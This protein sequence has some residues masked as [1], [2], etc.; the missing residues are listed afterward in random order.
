MSLLSFIVK[1]SWNNQMI[2]VTHSI[3]QSELPS[4]K[5]SQFVAR[6]YLVWISLGGAAQLEAW[7]E[8]G[9]S[10]KRLY[11]SHYYSVDV[12]PLLILDL[13]NVKYGWCMT[14]KVG[15]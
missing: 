15:K 6:M 13:S 12:E 9:I 3:I 4:K 10:M 7:Y 8:V 2:N 14:F 5:V 1:E 11:V